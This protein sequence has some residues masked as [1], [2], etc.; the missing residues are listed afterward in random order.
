VVIV[1]T[2]LANPI[3]QSAPAS[4]SKGSL[5]TSTPTPAIRS[6]SPTVYSP[7]GISSTATGALSLSLFTAC[8]ATV[9]TWIT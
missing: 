6:V 2:T 5:P 7:V 3:R 1:K 9:C 8:C 4:S